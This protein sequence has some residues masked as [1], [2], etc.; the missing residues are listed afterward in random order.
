MKE[1][2]FFISLFSL[3]ILSSCKKEEKTKEARTPKQYAVEDF[4]NT[5][6]IGAAGFNKDETKVLINSNVTGIANL[7]ELNIADTSTVALTKS[8]T[9]SNYAID[10]L[11]GSSKFIFSSDKGGNEN[12]HLYLMN[13]TDAALKD[14]TPWPN[15]A[16]NFIGWSQDKKNLYVSSNK[17]DIKYFDIIKLETLN[18]KPIVLYQNET[19]LTPSVV[20]KSERYIA[21]TKEIT[22]DKS[23]LY[24]YD[25]KT[26]TTKKISS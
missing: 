23:E 6:A 3:L 21:L 10:Y 16:N 11:P 7:Y 12:T 20:S 17:R 5:K 19:G 25:S 9:E 14:I 18:W 8:K 15:S 13:R 1:K 2:Y 26:K 4:Y 24:L 22:T